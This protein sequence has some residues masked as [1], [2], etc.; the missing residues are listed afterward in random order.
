MKNL[1]YILAT[2]ITSILIFV[3][4]TKDEPFETIAKDDEPK[5]LN[6]IFTTRQN[7]ELPIIAEFNRDANLVIEL[8]VTPSAFSTTSWLIDG[9]EVHQ[10]TEIDMNLKAGIYHLKMLVTTQAGKTTYREGTIKVNPLPE[11]PY[12]TAKN[13]ERFVVPGTKARLYGDNLN[14]IK[15]ILIGEKTTD[16]PTFIEGAEGNYIEYTVPNDLDEGQYRVIM[17]N[18]NGDEFGGN[19][20]TATHSPLIT[21]GA[22]RINPNSEWR[23]TGLNIDQIASLTI[24][25]ET[26]SNFIKQSKTE[27]VL[28]SPN[29]KA[30]T[31]PISGKTINNSDVQFLSD[32]KIKT[33]HSITFTSE[34]VLFEG[35]HYVSWIF[36]DGNPNK[37]F[38]L[39]GKDIFAPILP[40]AT[41]NIYYSIEPDDVDRQLQTTSG[42]WNMLPGTEAVILNENGT[43]EVKLTQEM[44]DLI[45][46]ED[47]FLCVGHGYYIDRVTLN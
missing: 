7:G 6:P 9:K 33:E 4:C 40:G 45:Q 35:H 31:Y 32:G 41:L 47:G 18:E 30:D 43:L 38:N 27:L 20:I 13:L 10:G 39:I 5:I 11:D 21:E 25:G 19:T 17:I 8:V 36:D 44:L 37:T 46:A 16:A 24:D 15:S 23:L 14:L 22:V 29:L 1:K 26:I 34:A 28:T 42:W 12:T 3:A 2:L